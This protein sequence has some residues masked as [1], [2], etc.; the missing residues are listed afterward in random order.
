MNEG[1]ILAKL[2]GLGRDLQSELN[3]DIEKY[4]QARAELDRIDNAQ[5]ELWL[6]VVGKRREIDRINKRL[7]Q[8]GCISVESYDEHPQFT[9]EMRKAEGRSGVDTASK[10]S[11]NGGN[12][13]PDGPEE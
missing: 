3:D 8:A 4:K 7:E 12:A 5:A 6:R 1:N 11:I 10:G 13:S 9:K 2:S